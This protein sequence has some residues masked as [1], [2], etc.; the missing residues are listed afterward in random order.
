MHVRNEIVSKITHDMIM[1]SPIHQTAL[2][3]AS[4]KSQNELSTSRSELI[5]FCVS[6]ILKYIQYNLAKVHLYQFVF[7]SVLS[8]RA[9]PCFPRRRPRPPRPRPPHHHHHNCCGKYVVTFIFFFIVL[10]T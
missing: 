3:C 7:I 9:P 6:N 5:T 10:T 2:S 8:P 1:I 4:P